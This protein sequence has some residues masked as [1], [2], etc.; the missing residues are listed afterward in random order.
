MQALQQ[1]LRARLCRHF[2]EFHRRFTATPETDQ[3]RLLSGLRDA[4]ATRP[5][6]ERGFALHWP[7]ACDVSQCALVPLA[8]VPPHSFDQYVY[9]EF[10]AELATRV[11]PPRD[12]G[13]IHL[14]PLVEN[15]VCFAELETR[16]HFPAQLVTT[17]SHKLAFTLSADVVQASLRG[18]RGGG[19]VTFTAGDHRLLLTN[20]VVRLPEREQFT[21]L[22]LYIAGQREPLGLDYEVLCRGTNRDLDLRSLAGAGVQCWLLTLSP[23]ALHFP[24]DAVCEV[25]CQSTGRTQCHFDLRYCWLEYGLSDEAVATRDR[26]QPFRY[27][28]LDCELLEA[29]CHISGSPGG[30]PPRVT[31]ESR[32]PTR[33]FETDTARLELLRQL[34]LYYAGGDDAMPR[35]MLGDEM[36]GVVADTPGLLSRLQGGTLVFQN[37]TLASF[38]FDPRAPDTQLRLRLIF[39]EDAV[40]VSAM[41][42]YIY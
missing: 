27:A 12:D 21:G 2:A 26:P 18:V 15:G 31:S 16:V 30:S 10:L 35:F 41:Q 6:S 19:S 1:E 23:F 3:W 37:H 9:Y 32:S 20:C 14:L 11:A 29:I 13:R 33:G 22:R 40:R 34:K 28:L 39:E 17:T 42:L 8:L 7:T 24:A 4:F 38:V 5:Q 36:L 25:L